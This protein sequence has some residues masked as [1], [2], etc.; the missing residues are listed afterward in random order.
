LGWSVSVRL[1]PPCVYRALLQGADWQQWV[2]SL[3]WHRLAAQWL[4]LMGNCRK[5]CKGHGLGKRFGGCWH[6]V[7]CG[8]SGC[9]GYFTLHICVLDS[10]AYYMVQR[11][12]GICGEE[13]QHR[14]VCR[15]TLRRLLQIACRNELELRCL[16]S[17]CQ[18]PSRFV[19]LRG[20]LCVVAGSQLADCEA[21]G[22]LRWLYVLSCGSCDRSTTVGLS[23]VACRIVK[24]SGPASR[25][26]EYSMCHAN[27]S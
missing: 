13:Q 11:V 21:C 16:L 17:S 4:G 1:R 19:S 25:S 14:F 8:S 10:K 7:V 22:D 5:E 6:C 27:H 15:L 23:S 9:S 2:G 24:P 20:P 3:L 18:V 12:G 26:G